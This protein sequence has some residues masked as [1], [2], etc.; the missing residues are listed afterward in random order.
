MQF[1]SLWLATYAQE[2]SS[3]GNCTYSSNV[4]RPLRILLQIVSGGHVEGVL[5]GRK[6]PR[7]PGSSIV[8][9]FHVP[10]D[11]LTMSFQSDFSNEEHFTGFAAY[12]VAVGKVKPASSESLYCPGYG[13]RKADI[14]VFLTRMP[15]LK[16]IPGEGTAFQ[17]GQY[18]CC[19][20]DTFS[21]LS[22]SLLHFLIFF[23]PL[24][25]P[26]NLG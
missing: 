1:R 2:D 24:G 15:Y 6:K 26:F 14:R 22:T 11:T 12:Y 13:G 16:E 4:I 8:E 23:L 19:F 17:Y 3:V 18:K 9:E 20:R 5:C 21:L 25:P 7:A 10:Y